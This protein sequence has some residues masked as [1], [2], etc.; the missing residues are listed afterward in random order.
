MIQETQAR[1]CSMEVIRGVM[2][3]AFGLLFG[4]SLN[5][6]RLLRRRTSRAARYAAGSEP[7]RTGLRRACRR[8]QVWNENNFV[9]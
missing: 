9:P 8:E 5:G 6:K 2:I 1:L 4:F 3:I 7:M